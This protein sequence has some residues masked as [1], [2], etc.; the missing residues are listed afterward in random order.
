M[1]V[2]YVRVQDEPVHQA[3]G[4]EPED[5]ADERT[6][7]PVAPSGQLETPDCRRLDRASSRVRCC[8]APATRV[9]AELQRLGTRLEGGQEAAADC[10]SR[11]EL[12][13]HQRAA[14]NG[15]CHQLML[16]GQRRHS[17]AEQDDGEDCGAHATGKC[18][19][20]V[21]PR[22]TVLSPAASRAPGSRDQ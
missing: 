20:G 4:Q 7:A 5:A 22:R 21:G 18:P 2:P 3:A 19:S 10:G 8:A 14:V 16:G 11:I 9:Q 13:A 1:F 12:D 15:L 17:A 6:R